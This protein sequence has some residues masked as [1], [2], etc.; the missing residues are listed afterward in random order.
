LWSSI[1]SPAKSSSK[2]TTKLSL[3]RLEDRVTP[4]VLN[5]GG[6]VLQTVEVQNLYLGSDWNQTANMNTA[7]QLEGFAKML[8]S[9]QYMSNLYY[10][11]YNVS[12]GSYSPGRVL[13][14]NIN[15]GNWLFDSNAPAGAANSTIQSDIEWAIHAGVAAQPDANRLYVVY[16]EPGVAVYDA[17]ETSQKN[18]LGYHSAFRDWYNS[19]VVIHYAVVTYPG[20]Y[21]PTSQSQYCPSD[22]A[23]LTCTASH[24]IAES[25]TDPNITLGYKGWYDPSKG[26]LGE[27]GDI[28]RM[29]RQYLNGYYV[30]LVANRND[31]PMTVSN[32][33]VYQIPS[34]G[35]SSS[36]GTAMGALQAPLS[37][38][39]KD[40]VHDFD[41]WDMYFG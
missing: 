16:V 30:Q 39:K 7:G 5:Y 31:Q 3:T 14:Y 37:T 10:A 33:T 2:P 38:F 20:G 9:S 13:N 15:K 26:S 6:G 23:E 18:F 24:E 12:T 8:V 40:K 1:T 19:S 35:M 25:V 34:T 41:S 29:Y 32:G 11:G 21:N 22:F 28:T 27:I 36:L 17:G 4:T